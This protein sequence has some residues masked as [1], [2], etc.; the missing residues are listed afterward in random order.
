MRLKGAVYNHK[1]KEKAKR[2][3]KKEDYDVPVHFMITKEQ[4]KKL[5]LYLIHKNGKIKRSEWFRELIN[6]L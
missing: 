2:D 5:N 4:F 6:K 1:D 3:L